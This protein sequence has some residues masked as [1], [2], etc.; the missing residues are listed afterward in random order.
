MNSKTAISPGF[1]NNG[2]AVVPRLQTT[3]FEPVHEKAGPNVW[4]ADTNVALA[5][6]ASEIS[7]FSAGFGPLFVTATANVT[8]WPDSGFS[9]TRDLEIERS[10]VGA[11]PCTWND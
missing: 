4:L 10:A 2:L 8:L 11:L 1:K 9:P 3:G 7:T 6:S 5:G